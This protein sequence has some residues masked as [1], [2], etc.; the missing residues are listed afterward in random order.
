MCPTG[1]PLLHQVPGHL[2]FAWIPAPRA[3][4]GPSCGNQRLLQALAHGEWKVACLLHQ[5]SQSNPRQN[6][7]SRDPTWSRERSTGRSLR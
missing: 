7:A 4:L 1:L 5:S 3:I 2:L 6:S